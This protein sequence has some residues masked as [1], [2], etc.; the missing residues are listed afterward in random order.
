MTILTD[1]VSGAYD[2]E[3]ESIRDAVHKRRELVEDQEAAILLSKI[4]A[5]DKVR[6]KNINPKYLAGTICTVT[7]RQLKMNKKSNKV[8]VTLDKPVRRYSGG[9]RV[10]VTCIELVEGEDDS[11]PKRVLP[12]IQE[13][14]DALKKGDE[15]E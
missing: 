6:L 7:P 11:F 15:D 10:P 13:F 5:G 9:M 1:I 12:T 2:N 3:L 4:K 14:R 8:Y